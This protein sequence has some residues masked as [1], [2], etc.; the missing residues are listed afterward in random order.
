M[1]SMAA[2]TLASSSMTRMRRGDFT[3]SSILLVIC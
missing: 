1:A 2:P 3:G